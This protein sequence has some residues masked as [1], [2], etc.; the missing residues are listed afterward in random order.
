MKLTTIY[1]ISP[2]FS[3]IFLISASQ[4]LKALYMKK[5]KQLKTKK[6]MNNNDFNKRLEEIRKLRHQT[7][8]RIARFARKMKEEEDDF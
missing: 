2:K 7:S 1:K 6:I 8:E 3:N 5:N 4:S